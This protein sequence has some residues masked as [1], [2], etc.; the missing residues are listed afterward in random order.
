VP[1]YYFDVREGPR[2]IADPDG[3]ECPDLDAAEHEA[4][5]TAASIA[6]D[7]FPRGRAHDVTVEVR[8]A[9]G[10]RVFTVT[11]TMRTNRVVAPPVAP[12]APA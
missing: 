11:V 8:D 9:H 2:F 10:H 4:T 1:R 3:L 12:S 7:V 5:E 6:R